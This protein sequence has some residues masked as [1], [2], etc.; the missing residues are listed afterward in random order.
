MQQAPPPP[1]SAT[2]IP[3]RFG[4][5]RERVLRILAR[6]EASIRPPSLA[7]PG[8]RPHRFSELGAGSAR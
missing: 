1:R 2:A 6:W 3:T 7:L 4:E 8:D 5:Q